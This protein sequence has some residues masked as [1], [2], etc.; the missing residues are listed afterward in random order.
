MTVILCTKGWLST[1]RVYTDTMSPEE[2]ERRSTSMTEFT[3]EW[4][5]DISSEDL[6]LV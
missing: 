3:V 2:K 5:P 4:P 1:L 6:S